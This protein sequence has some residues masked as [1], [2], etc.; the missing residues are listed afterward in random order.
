LAISFP[1]LLALAYELVPRSGGQAYSTL[2]LVLSAGVFLG[3]IAVSRI[4][5]IGSLRTLATGLLLTGVF[6]VLIAIHNLPLIF[7]AVVLFVASFGNPIYA[8]A[9]Q[10]A[11]LEAAD[12]SAR[13]SIMA[14][15]FGFVQTA[16]VIGT[17][18]GGLIT[19]AFTAEAAYGVLGVGLVML[20]LYAFAAGRSTVNPLLGGPYQ[21][22]LGQGKT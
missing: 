18:V 7:V 9:N 5:A 12:A 16:S 19:Q 3:S 2:E 17:G 21:E 1:A 14:T 11:L 4:G 20:A 22:A 8:V 10:T 13:G 6:S 15:R